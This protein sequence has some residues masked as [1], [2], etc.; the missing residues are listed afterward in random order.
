MNSLFNQWL[1][2]NSKIEGVLGCAVRYADKTCFTLTY[3]PDFSQPNMELAWRCMADT[4]HVLKLHKKSVQR[5]L[6]VFEKA[7]LHCTIRND[8]VC[9]GVFT[10]PEPV[11]AAT[12]EELARLFSEFQELRA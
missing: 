8:G 9:L 12:K 7:D 5:L 10:V 3:N 6:W 1:R 2:D 4:F 11:P